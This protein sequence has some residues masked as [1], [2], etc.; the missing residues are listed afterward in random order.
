MKTFALSCFVVVASLAQAAAADDPPFM[1]HLFPPELLMRNQHEIGLSDEQRST[2]TGAIR[3]TQGSVLEIEWA[4][5]DEARKLGELLAAERVDAEAALAQVARVLDLEGQV[6][7]AHM[8]L[9]IRIKN[10]LDPEQR[11]KLDAL[12]PDDFAA[13]LDQLF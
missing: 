5:Q 6:K 11:S 8:G 1:R 2:I 13:L 10:T 9:L 7:R 4:M 12:R 3:E